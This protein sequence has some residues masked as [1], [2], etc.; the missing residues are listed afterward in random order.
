[1]AATRASARADP[2]SDAFATVLGQ[3]QI[4]ELPDDPD[5][6][7]QMLKDMA[8]PGRDHAR[9][10]VPRRQAAA[11]EIRSSR[12]ASAATCSPPTR[13]SRGWSPSTSRPSRASSDWRGST[14]VGFRGSALNAR[15]AFAPAKGDEQHERY[16]FS[17]SGPLWKKH[18][19]LALS[20]DGVDAFDT[21]TIVAALPSGYL[22]TRSASRTTR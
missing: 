17:L 14:N 20:A 5:E 7:E 3:P 10:R 16:G 6:M 2:R 22:P 9:Q 11:E 1:M 15:N 21:K 4:D 18:T 19:S 12:F 8:G 13:T